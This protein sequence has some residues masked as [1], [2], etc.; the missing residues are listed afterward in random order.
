MLLFLFV[1][2]FASESLDDFTLR[3]D[4]VYLIKIIQIGYYKDRGWI[5]AFRLDAFNIHTSD[6]LPLLMSSPALTAKSK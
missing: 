1:S 4:N 3:V 6:S 5:I 2:F